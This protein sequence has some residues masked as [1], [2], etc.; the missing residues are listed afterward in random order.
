MGVR[1]SKCLGAS[2][3]RA[4]L[5]ECAVAGPSPFQILFSCAPMKRMDARSKKEKEPLDG[6]LE[7]SRGSHLP[8]GVSHGA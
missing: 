1:C 2:E 4:R 6:L 8:G 3:E 7:G 5:C